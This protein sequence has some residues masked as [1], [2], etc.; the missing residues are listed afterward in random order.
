MTQT[1]HT[2]ETTE[3]GGR[4][5][6]PPNNNHT[7]VCTDR[8][9][10][11]T[12]V[13][14]V[15]GRNLAPSTKS[16]KPSPG[17]KGSEAGTPLFTRAHAAVGTPGM[18]SAALGLGTGTTLAPG[19]PKAAAQPMCYHLLLTNEML[20]HFHFIQFH[21][22]VSLSVKSS[23]ATTASV[24]PSCSQHCCRCICWHLHAV[25]N[26]VGHAEHNSEMNVLIKQ[27]AAAI[28]QP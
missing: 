27:R 7:F 5:V 15:P 8:F 24:L 9:L 12:W 2:C 3:L 28:R 14:E 26:K 23:N 19:T 21:C 11:Q 10:A 22:V 18:S 20:V 13:P 6:R 1:W 25:P 4:E 17:L 16:V